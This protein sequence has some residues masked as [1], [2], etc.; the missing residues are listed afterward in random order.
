[1]K[2]DVVLGAAVLGE[3]FAE[4]ATGA[5]MAMRRQTDAMVSQ[6]TPFPGASTVRLNVYDALIELEAALTSAAMSARVVSTRMRQMVQE[7]LER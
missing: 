7:E 1:M 3:A 5:L 2:T 4:G 6:W